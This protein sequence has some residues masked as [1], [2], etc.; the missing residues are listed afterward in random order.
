MFPARRSRKL[1]DGEIKEG[2]LDSDNV[3]AAT[4]VV[5]TREGR[6]TPSD[7][8]SHRRVSP[9]QETAVKAAFLLKRSEQGLFHN[10]K[11]RWV[12]L[13]VVPRSTLYYF[14][15]EGSLAPQGELLL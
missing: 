1:R 3:S 7:A 6:G 4:L 8:V 2:A 11:R 13:T 5:R 14:E 9:L 15:D 10:W 12:V